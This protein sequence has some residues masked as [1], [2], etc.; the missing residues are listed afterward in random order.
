MILPSSTSDTS[1]DGTLPSVVRPEAFPI[2][3]RNVNL[4]LRRLDWQADLGYVSSLQADQRSRMMAGWHCICD[5]PQD[6]RTGGA[7][8]AAD[9]SVEP[10]RAAQ[11]GQLIKREGTIPKL[12][13]LLM[14]VES[15]GTSGLGRRHGRRWTDHLVNATIVL[16][17]P[18]DGIQPFIALGQALVSHDQRIRIAALKVFETSVRSLSWSRVL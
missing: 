13:I 3:S 16:Y 1:E 10:E 17:R 6:P 14:I 8:A 11:P 18:S 2:A 12:A 15:R 9:V 4:T 5:Y 7:V